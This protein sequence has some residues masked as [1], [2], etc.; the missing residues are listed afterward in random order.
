M[1]RTN[2]TPPSHSVRPPD[3]E[4]SRPAQLSP[5]GNR[6]QSGRPLS[7]EASAASIVR[8]AVEVLIEHQKRVRPVDPTGKLMEPV[9]VEVKNAAFFSSTLPSRFR[10]RTN[11][12]TRAGELWLSA[13]VIIFLLNFARSI[14]GFAYNKPVLGPRGFF[15]SKNIFK[16]TK[17]FS[18]FSSYLLLSTNNKLQCGI[19]KMFVVKTYPAKL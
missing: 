1:E 5:S 3:E 4:T 9:G 16:K 19:L 17:Y 18:P 15:Y 2:K 8:L 7:G 13:Q 11:G 14:I 12:S 6:W 10:S